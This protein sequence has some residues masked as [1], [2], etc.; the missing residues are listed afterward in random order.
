MAARSQTGTRRQRTFKD[1]RKLARSKRFAKYYFVASLVILGASTIFWSVIG[2]MIESQNADQLANTFLF[3]TPSATSGALLPTQHTFLLKTPLFWLVSLFGAQPILFTIATVLL[4]L[5]TVAGLAF[6]LSRIEKRPLVLGT[7]F[8]A[9]AAVLMYIPAQSYP[10]SLLPANFAMLTTRNIEYVLFIGAIILTLKAQ[11]LRSVLFLLGIVGFIILFASDRL[12]VSLGLGTALISGLF[13]LVKRRRD[14]VKVSLRLL[15]SVVVGYV[16][17]TIGL[18]LLSKVGLHTTGSADPYGLVTSPTS[19]VIAIVYGVLGILTN[20]GANPAFDAVALKDIPAHLVWGVFSPYGLGYIATVGVII[21]AVRAGRVSLTSVLKKPARR[22]RPASWQTLLAPILLASTLTAL[23]TFI[24]SNHYYPADSRYLGVAL[25][26]GFITLAGSFMGRLKLDRIA[27]M[28]LICGVA[29]LFGILFQLQ[30]FSDQNAA[31]AQVSQRDTLIAATLKAH[32]VSTVL[33]SYWRVL[34]IKLNLPSINV[35]PLESC[36]S[37]RQVLSSKAWQPNL[38]TTSFAYLLRLDGAS[39]SDPNCTLAQVTATYGR[40]DSSVVIAGTRLDPKELLLFYD[41][42]I[43]ILKPGTKNTQSDT[44]T[45]VSVDTMPYTTCVNKT[46]MQFV[47]HQDDDILFMNP[48]LQHD[49]SMGNCIRTVYFTAGDAGSN[50]SYWVD[51]QHGSEA[52]YA[53]ML[54]T[55]NVTWT[56][57]MVSLDASHIITI[58]NPRGNHAISL[59]FLRLPDGNVDG[60]GFASQHHQSL[61]KLYARQILAMNAVDDRTQSYSYDALTGGLIHLMQVY[62]PEELRSQSTDPGSTVKDHSDHNAVGEFTT[63]SFGAYQTTNPAATLTY[64]LGYP[65]HN[66]PVNVMGEDYARKVATFLSFSKFDAATCHTLT[67]C[68]NNSVYGLYL[69][70][71]YPSP[72]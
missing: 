24:A 42:G 31:V 39:A 26:A 25:F 69:G 17:A 2:S 36:T 48:N 51:R 22:T 40:P 1:F 35:T 63:L 9:L 15:I 32:L 58:A 46:V 8:F 72:F 21:A 68:N 11:R 5:L 47:A 52:A 29:V 54:G 41:E 45:P 53:Q 50:Q 66:L 13:F 19:L 14:L 44:I 27:S 33:G 64:Y 30:N 6:I 49:I 16:G 4:S 38:K 3:D 59:I 65:V 70:R 61:K 55:P 12:F 56:E 10:G 28:G 62:K 7:L 60:R 23:L 43:H 37:E 57:R 71:E 20:F 18:L 34:P 67:Q